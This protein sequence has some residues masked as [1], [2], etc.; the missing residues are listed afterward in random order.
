MS[1]TLEVYDKNIDPTGLAVVAVLVV[2]AGRARSASACRCRK[3]TRSTSASA[4]EHTNLTLF[5]NSPPVYYQFVQ[6]FGYST[7]SYIVSAGWSRDTRDDIL[8]PT[9]GRLQ[10]ALIEVGL[11]FGDLAYYKLQYVNQSFC[12]GLWATSS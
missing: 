9:F 12:A 1:R 6:E 5:A 7:N 8:Y 3:S 4:I 2:D 11:P 10:C